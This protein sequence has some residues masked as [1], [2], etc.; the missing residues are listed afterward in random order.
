MSTKALKDLLAPLGGP[1]EA[2]QLLR[3]AANT[4]Q[5][6][7]PLTRTIIDRLYSLAK[8]LAPRYKKLGDDFPEIILLLTMAVRASLDFVRQDAT[9]DEKEQ[10]VTKLEAAPTAVDKEDWPGVARAVVQAVRV[11]MLSTLQRHEEALPL[12]RQLASSVE[13]AIMPKTPG[14]AGNLLLWCVDVYL[15]AFES[16]PYKGDDEVFAE[17]V[18]LGH[19]VLECTKRSSLLLEVSE[20]YIFSI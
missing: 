3:S 12:T 7:P 4:L 2:L 16:G 5:L 14:G 17:A 6:E 20:H 15:S 9:T 13:E 8:L 18:R 10:L 1:D 19:K 11:G